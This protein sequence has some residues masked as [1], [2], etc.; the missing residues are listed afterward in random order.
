MLTYFFICFCIR[1]CIACVS[2]LDSPFLPHV[3][4]TVF[5]LRDSDD[6]QHQVACALA[7]KSPTEYKHWLLAYVRRLVQEADIR[8]LQETCEFLLGPMYRHNLFLS[9][10]LALWRD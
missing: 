2:I 6:L 8:R 10:S 1:I 4:V 7:L 5:L 3:S 9:L